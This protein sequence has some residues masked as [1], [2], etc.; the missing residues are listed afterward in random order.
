MYSAF[1]VI[2]LYLYQCGS[3]FALVNADLFKPWLDNFIDCHTV[4]IGIFCI[5]DCVM[6]AYYS[7][8]FWKW[9]NKRIK[10]KK[11]NEN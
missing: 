10:E 8:K 9:F 3:D 11:K 1:I 6:F 2:I 5:L 7:V 4:L